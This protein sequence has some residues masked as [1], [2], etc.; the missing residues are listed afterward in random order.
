M[1][2]EPRGE[3]GEFYKNLSLSVG[4]TLLKLFF[5]IIT[6]REVIYKICV[7]LTILD[8][9]RLRMKNETKEK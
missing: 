5:N 1:H 6:D 9:F 2:Y 7:Q 3:T 8:T 4:W